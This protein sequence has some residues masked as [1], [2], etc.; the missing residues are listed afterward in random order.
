MLDRWSFSDTR[1]HVDARDRLARANEVGRLIE[2]MDPIQTA[3]VIFPDD[4]RA[5]LFGPAQRKTATVMVRTKLRQRLTEDVANVIITLVAR[6]KAGLDERDVV[7]TDQFATNFHFSE[8]SGLNHLARLKWDAEYRL[9]SDMRRTVE[10]LMARFVPGMVYEGAVHAFPRHDIQYDERTTVGREYREG[11]PLRTQTDRTTKSAISRPPG[12]VGVMPNVIRSANMG[13]DALGRL[14]TE[15]SYNRKQSDETL[16]NSWIDTRIVSAPAVRNLTIAAII[17][18]PYR[19]KLDESGMPVPLR[20]PSGTLLLDQDTGRPLYERESAALLSADRIDE[21]KRQIAHAAGINLSDIPEKIEVTQVPWMAPHHDARAAAS[22]S[23]EILRMLREHVTSIITLL[24]LA[25]VVWFVYRQT[26]RPIPTEADDE[27]SQE[28]MTLA[29]GK[30]E[31]EEEVNVEWENL[32]S[33]VC[34][35]IAEDPKRAANQLRRWMRKE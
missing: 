5:S 25:G 34:A 29:M 15:T 23:W 18:L 31:D 33:K 3:R 12:E 30:D 27:I 13:A 24:F 10:N 16:Q 26:T 20:N 14:V 19:Q 11:P 35:A 7:V 32:R 4:V 28:S 6:S 2:M 22:P 1:S 21:L 17:H 9:N 8:R